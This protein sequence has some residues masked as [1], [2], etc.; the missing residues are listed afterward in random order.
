MT[1]IILASQRAAPLIERKD[2]MSIGIHLQRSIFTV[3]AAAG[4]LI[5]PVETGRERGIK[6]RK[7]REIVIVFITGTEIV[8]ETGIMTLRL[9]KQGRGRRVAVEIEMS[10]RG[11]WIR[12]G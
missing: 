5:N 11:T 3:R 12:T 8:T 6:T 9:K 4:A 1:N 7:V 10:M 2:G